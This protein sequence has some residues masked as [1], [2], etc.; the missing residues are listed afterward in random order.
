MTRFDS[1]SDAFVPELLVADLEEMQR[2]LVRFFARIGDSQWDYHTEKR[3][4][5]W[6]L[7]ETLAHVTAIAEIFDLAAEHTINGIPFDHPLLNRSEHLIEIN[8]ILIAERIDTPPGTLVQ[9]L[10]DALGR[11][12]QLARNMPPE[13]W[14]RTVD[15]RV[16]NRPMP[17]A[18][19]VASQLSHA[20][21]VHAAQLPIG[22]GAPPLW[23][24]YLPDLLRRQLTRFFTQ[25]S[26]AY[27]PERADGLR[28][29]VEFI[30][31]GREGGTWHLI[32]GTHG[33]EP[34]EGRAA[35]SLF[36]LRMRSTDVLCRVIT[37]QIRPV[38]G[39]MTGQILPWG[40]VPLMLRFQRY[41]VGAPI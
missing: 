15:L 28:G 6:T 38:Y 34:V 30:A 11:T 22:I 2:V 31:G 16:Y 7:R 35:K 19:L 1:P 20:G 14:D 3:N 23:H 13:M 40:D 41:F 27:R 32:L 26:Y 18:H 29:A 4:R 36:S 10:L 21:L 25:M 33:A 9:A 39:V 12:A 8:K 37:G 24:D 17:L 5:G